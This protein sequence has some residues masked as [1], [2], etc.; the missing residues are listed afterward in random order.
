ML[1]TLP[2]LFALVLFGCGSGQVGEAG[3]PGDGGATGSEGGAYVDPSDAGAM[4]D[5]GDDAPADAIGETKSCAYSLPLASLTAHNTAA[6]PH[7]DQAHFPANFGTTTWIA[8]SGTTMPVDPKKADVSLNPVTPGHVS[9]VDVHTL[10]PSRPDLRWFAHITPWFRAG[11]GGGHVDIGLEYASAEYVASMVTDMKNRGFDGVIIDWYGKGSYSDQ[12]TLLLQKHLASISGNT[13]KFIVMMDKGISGL[14]QAVLETQVKYVQSQYFGDPAY[15]LEGGEPIL[16]FFGVENAI[17][18]SAMAQVKADTGGKM[19]WVL[20]GSGSV[21][22][23]WVDQAFDWT[24]DF[25]DGPSSTDPYALAGVAG[26][27]G[28]IGKQSKKA[29]GSMVAGFNGTLTKSVSWSM[30]KYL[31]R[32]SGA[33]LVQWAKKIDAVIPANVTRMQWAT[34][35]DWEEGTQIESGVENDFAV[36]AKL[37]GGTLS[38][39]FTSGTGDEST[40]DHYEIYASTDGTNAVDLGAVKPGV[41]TFELGNAHCSVPAGAKLFV[42]A[43]GKPNI[44]DHLGAPASE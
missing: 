13:F 2:C 24:H 25:H 31:P 30:G 8:Q 41:H 7:Y 23:S 34:W 36:Q 16:M 44:R 40:I 35:S 21:G 14:S 9:N 38:W 29:F 5:A 37:S 15:E 6:S 10:V 18:G 3:A 32:G 42:N 1:R 22:N 27:Y 17:G 43:V 20:Q 4:S 39:T 33:C 28:A 26:F 12:V 19:V 11:G